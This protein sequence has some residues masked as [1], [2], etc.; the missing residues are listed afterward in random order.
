MLG[1][2]GVLGDECHQ[3]K[4]SITA[5]PTPPHPNLMFASHSIALGLRPIPCSE[6]TGL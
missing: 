2:G 4:V 5:L 3:L 6:R 1:P